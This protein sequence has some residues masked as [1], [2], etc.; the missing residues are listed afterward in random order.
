MKRK[1]KDANI[2]YLI[3]K[4]IRFAG[5]VIYIY[6]L[7]HVGTI[8]AQ[9]GSGLSSTDE[10][11]RYIVEFFIRK[12]YFHEKEDF[13]RNIKLVF[14]REL[15][16]GAAMDER[17]FGIYDIGV[18]ISHRKRYVLIKNK[19]KISIHDPENL[20]SLLRLVLRLLEKNNQDD[21]AVAVYVSEIVNLYKRNQNIYPGTIHKK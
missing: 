9:V 19:R 18:M 14:S 17:P 8:Q 4:A 10:Y 2:Q 13:D 11:K 6:F 1:V 21:E 20:S 16:H 3:N 7:F 5:F 15:F 12:N